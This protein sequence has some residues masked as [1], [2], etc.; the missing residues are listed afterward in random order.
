[1]Q[2]EIFN[3]SEGLKM[4]KAII[5]LIFIGFGQCWVRLSTKLFL[6]LAKGE[7]KKLTYHF[8]KESI[9]VWW[10]CKY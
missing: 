4:I 6:P 1:M 2:L 9:H 8:D 10:D 7:Q 5:T 3:Q